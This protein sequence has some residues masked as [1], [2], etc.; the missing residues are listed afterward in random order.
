MLGQ[1]E[2]NLEDEEEEKECQQMDLSIFSARGLTQPNTMKLQGEVK[3]RLVLV[4]IDS[5]A[6]HN[7][8][9]VELVSQLGLLVES[10]S[11]CNARLGDGHKKRVSGCCQG[12]KVKLGNY[13]FEET[14]FL[15]GLGGVDVIL[16]VA[17][18]LTLG[19][20]KVNWKTLT[21]NFCINGQQVQ[22]RGDPKLS[23]TLV[24][25]KTLKKEKDIKAVSLIGE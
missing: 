8:I 14:F 16:G 22:I 3:E 5:G 1:I 4:L 23:R 15:F 7:F 10:T 11:S 19:D 21:M 20:V 17:W 18:L 2:E 25:S 6:S 24:T 13:M 12:V 9:Y